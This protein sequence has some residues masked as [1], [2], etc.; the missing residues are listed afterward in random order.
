MNVPSLHLCRCETRY[1][2]NMSASGFD[3]VVFVRLVAR[4]LR[5]RWAVPAVVTSLWDLCR[6]VVDMEELSQMVKDA[7]KCLLNVHEEWP[8]GGVSFYG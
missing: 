2:G 8:S 6:H 3:V 5:R 1:H 4:G 7:V